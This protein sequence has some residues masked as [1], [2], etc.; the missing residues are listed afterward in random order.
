MLRPVPPGL[1]H[2]AI[3][4]L[5]PVAALKSTGGGVLF[6]WDIS[7]ARTK[8]TGKQKGGRGRDGQRKKQELERKVT[9]QDHWENHASNHVQNKFSS[10]PTYALNNIRA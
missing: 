2:C 7:M 5:S 3:L 9:R 1:A 10:F 6:C 4:A 8:R